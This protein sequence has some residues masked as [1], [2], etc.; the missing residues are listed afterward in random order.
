MGSDPNLY[1][2]GEAED[3]LTAIQIAQ[4]VQPDVVVMDIAMP[5]MSGIDAT[6]EITSTL[7]RTRVL[8]LSSYGDDDSVRSL[9]AAGASGYITKHSASEDLLEAIRQVYQGK[10]YFSPRIARRLKRQQEKSF[11]NG[12]PRK[13]DLT[14]REVQVITAI[15]QG[16]AT[17]DVAQQLGLSRKT[18][19]KHRQSLMNKLDIHE[20]AGLTRYAASK[21]LLAK[22]GI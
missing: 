3:G 2:S 8:V 14:K 19:E 18:V 15:A 5:R 12:R 20:I 6:R 22:S 16:L 17:R 13:A 1:V 4:S 11:L 21:G 7:P 10:Q 9:L